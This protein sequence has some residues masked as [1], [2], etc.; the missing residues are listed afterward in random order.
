MIDA[1][2]AQAAGGID[3]TAPSS[4]DCRD[5]LIAIRDICH[6][7]VMSR[8]IADEWNDHQSKF[9][10]R[11][12]RQMVARRKLHPIDVIERTSLRQRLRRAAS[13]AKAADAMMKDAHLI[14]AA[15][16]SDGTVISRD[17]EA[18]LAFDEAAAAVGELRGI[19]WVNP[20]KGAEE[21]IK[22]LARGAKPVKS[23]RL[24]SSS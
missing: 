10:R 21:A 12:R 24:G 17:E 14:E 22:W 11:W 16:E 5:C 15:M 18:R 20:T 9:A 6:R 4:R 8:A 3:A 23:R 13:N 1:D 2:V 7:F 19:V